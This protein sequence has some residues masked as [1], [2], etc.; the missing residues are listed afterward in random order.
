MYNFDL[1][2]QS[3]LHSVAHWILLTQKTKQSS[4]SSTPLLY[5]VLC[6]NKSDLLHKNGTN[7]MEE[8]MRSE[9]EELV[10]KHHLNRYVETS[11]K[12]NQNI[13]SLFDDIVTNILNHPLANLE[14]EPL[15]QR[16]NSQTMHSRNTSTVVDLVDASMLQTPRGHAPTISLVPTPTNTL[17]TAALEMEIK[18][19]QQQNKTLHQTI[20][21]MDSRIQQLVLLCQDES[22]QMNQLEKSMQTNASTTI[23]STATK[24]EAMIPL[25]LASVCAV[26]ATA[27]L[28]LVW[29]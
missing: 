27:G 13:D 20:E 7:E 16:K 8:S 5:Q 2:H 17:G 1:S 3:T 19:L 22:V 23:T 29:K 18:I 12:L 25:L 28:F 15:L 26:A 14:P 9:I 10:S 24:S 11:S 4:P 6:G 21:A